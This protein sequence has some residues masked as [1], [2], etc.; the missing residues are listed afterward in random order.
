MD[1]GLEKIL[2]PLIGLGD[3]DEVNGPTSIPSFLWVEFLVNKFVLPYLVA[4][5]SAFRSVDT[6]VVRAVLNSNS[7]RHQDILS[8]E[9]IPMDYENDATYFFEYL[10]FRLER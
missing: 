4:E 5:R 1:E 8:T 2:E 3:D 9:L 6:E 10:L 7:P